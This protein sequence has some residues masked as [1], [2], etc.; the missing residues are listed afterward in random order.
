MSFRRT[1]TTMTAI[2][3][4]IAANVLWACGV[5]A[6]EPNRV[7]WSP[8]RDDAVI[9]EGVPSVMQP[10]GGS[11]NRSLLSQRPQSLSRPAPIRSRTYVSQSPTPAESLP[12][13]SG[14][15]ISPDGL[16]VPSEMYYDDGGAIIDGEMIP[17]GD[18]CNSCGL[19]RCG[20]GR[21]C[22]RGG[23]TW[24]PLCLFLPMPPIDCF[25]AYGGVQGFTG[26]ANR[27]GSGSFGFHEGFNW[28]I[29][30]SCC[31]AGQFGATWTQNN[32]DGN[33]LTPDQRNQVF[34]TGGLFHRA[35]WG[36]QGG[37]V[38]DYLRDNWDYRA[39]LA[40][41]RAEL[42]WLWCGCNEVGVWAAIG[43]NDAKDIEI[44][45]P[46]FTNTTIRTVNTTSTLEV[47]D[48]YA[49]FFRRQ[50]ACGGNGRLFGGFTSHSQGLVGGD[51]TVP[52]NPCWSL[53]TSFMY[54]TP[55]SNN[56]DDDNARTDPRFNRE[57]WNVGISLVW[58]PCPRNNCCPNYSRPLFNVA[59]NG[60]F[61]TR[62]K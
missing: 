23:C 48:L 14:S 43:M 45:R 20:L 62:F 26:P 37:V 31:M 42:S 28:G 38:F 50:F 56:E 33:Y 36:L 3:A 10:P 7:A 61:V 1:S 15:P 58:T 46:V 59:D 17:G 19:A 6:A 51:A 47:N 30:I 27:G 24:V 2:A 52:I 55:G 57:S 49:L 8:S 39:D 22:G 34:V 53:R 25:E 21:W 13:V 60:T 32:F 54:V 18:C 41:I 4:A 44:R 12:T 40:Q 35:D 5:L 16:P 9:I 29:P 11:L